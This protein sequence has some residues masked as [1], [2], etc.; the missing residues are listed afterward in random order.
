MFVNNTFTESL[1]MLRCCAYLSRDSGCSYGAQEAHNRKSPYVCRFVCTTLVAC[2]RNTRNEEDERT[3]APNI[4]GE[5]NRNYNISFTRL[6]YNVYV[7]TFLC[8]F[9]MHIIVALFAKHP[10]TKPE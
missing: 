10:N 7:F 9:I 3:H 6:K 2:R 1:C 5:Q 8:Y 4:C